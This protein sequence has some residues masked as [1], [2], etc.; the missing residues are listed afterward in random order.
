MCG[1]KVESS[2]MKDGLC[3]KCRKELDELSKDDDDPDAT[4]EK[5]GGEIDEGDYCVCNF[6]DCALKFWFT[7]GQ[8]LKVALCQKLTSTPNKLHFEGVDDKQDGFYSNSFTKIKM[9][10]NV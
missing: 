8:V 2:E 7:T 3:L 4:F 5:V 6:H 9:L 10:T 1:D